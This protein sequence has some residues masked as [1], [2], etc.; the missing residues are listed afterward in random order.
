M[1]ITYIKLVNVASLYTGSNVNTLELDFSNTHSNIILIT[2]PNGCGKTTLE[3]CLHPFAYNGS[4]DDR[5]SESLII[6]KKDGYKEVH[7]TDGTNEYVI[8]HFY[9]ASGENSHSVKSYISKNDVELNTNGNVTSF[10]EWVQIELGMTMEYLKLVRLGPNM[11]NFIDMKPTERKSYVGTM[12][13][14]TEIYLQKLKKVNNDIKVLKAM[15]AQDVNRLNKLNISDISTEESYLERLK[16][17]DLK[18]IE[19]VIS[20]ISSRGA[21]LKSK[22]QEIGK[23]TNEVYHELEDSRH[24]LSDMSSQLRSRKFKILSDNESS[25]GIQEKLIQYTSKQEALKARRSMLI[26]DADNCSNDLSELYI[27]KDK[28]DN[29]EDVKSLIV[30]IKDLEREVDKDKNTYKNFKPAY[31]ASDINELLTLL[32]K[33]QSTLSATYEIGE[34][35]IKKVAKLMARSENVDSY[36]SRKLDTIYSNNITSRSSEVLAYLKKKFPSL[37]KK[38]KPK[39]G[40]SSCQ[41]VQL[42]DSIL[43]L[44][45]QD[46]D[47]NV[48]TEEFYSYMQ[49]AYSNISAVRNEMIHHDELFSRMPAEILKM[50]TIEEFFSRVGKLEFIYDKTVINKELTIITEYELYLDKIERLEK[51]RKELKS[52]TSTQGSDFINERISELEEKLNDDKENASILSEQIAELDEKISDIRRLNETKIEYETLNSNFDKENE[53]FKSLTETWNSMREYNDELQTLSK[54]YEQADREKK[55]ILDNITAVDSRIRLYHTLK[56]ELKKIKKEY[57]EREMTRYSLSSKEGIPLIYI[58]LYL[59]KTKKIVNELLDIV[60]G[61]ELRI[62]D[63][64]VSADAFNIPYEKNGNI[65]SDAHYASQGEMSF[66][67]TILSF[68]LSMQSIVKY[69]IMLLDEVDGALDD[70]NRKNFILVLDHLMKKIGA[71]QVFLIT[72]NNMFDMYDVSTIDLSHVSNGLTNVK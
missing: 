27:K 26:N 32:D 18:E 57:D 69:N 54:R 65:V 3:S 19:D 14:E 33:W 21:V 40:D 55:R 31:T 50:F 16:S 47:K 59:K 41:Y 58:N 5:S 13:N 2:G 49:I 37:T 46:T 6:K 44:S 39:C 23:N 70:N 61:G 38:L 30:I 63:F 10:K 25:S 67:S 17:K 68:A 53:N 60:Y 20:S 4:G 12:L 24:S 1:R 64:E 45:E 62:T 42:V 9:T 72:H 15:I 43:E 36:I 51:A 28:L 34:K 71:E 52:M 22:L 48:E 66:L 29:N 56:K 11:T 7:I 35:P 8:K